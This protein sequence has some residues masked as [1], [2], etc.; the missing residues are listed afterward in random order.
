MSQLGF[1]HQ[2]GYSIK[3]LRSSRLLRLCY[4][5]WRVRDERFAGWPIWQAVP[6]SALA[7]IQFWKLALDCIWRSRRCGSRMGDTSKVLG[8]AKKEVYGAFGVVI[9]FSAS[10]R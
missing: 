6:V 10:T 9:G 7:E 5:D 2:L 3:L 4:C 1:L 8:E